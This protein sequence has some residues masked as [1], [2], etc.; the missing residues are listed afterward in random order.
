MGCNSCK[1]KNKVGEQSIETQVKKSPI[2]DNI[3]WF[4]VKLI[5]F[6]LMIVVIIPTVTVFLI[7][8]LFFN[9]I[10][11]KQIDVSNMIHKMIN[12]LVNKI[13]AK[14]QKEEEDEDSFD[15]SEYSL[16]DI[17]IEEID[18]EQHNKN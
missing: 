12:S 6:V 4:P 5:L 2:K 16:D 11:G 10:I 1:S 13:N 17:E 18:Y 7:Y 14:R 3:I 9:I 8:I 15:E